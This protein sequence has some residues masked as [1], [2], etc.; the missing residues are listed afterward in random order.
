MENL[1]KFLDNY[2]T[3]F[4]IGCL[5]LATFLICL[6]LF[7]L[8]IG[9]LTHESYNNNKTSYQTCRLFIIFAQIAWIMLQITFITEFFA[10]IISAISG[11]GSVKNIIAMFICFFLIAIFGDLAIRIFSNNGRY[12]GHVTPYEKFARFMKPIFWED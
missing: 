1:F 8:I 10:N 4:S 7:F 12:V 2:L 11:N 3:K 5:C 6:A 9:I